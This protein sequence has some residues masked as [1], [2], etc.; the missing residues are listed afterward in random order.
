MSLFLLSLACGSNSSLDVSDGDPSVDDSAPVEEEEEEDPGT[1]L[2]AGDWTGDLRIEGSSSFDCD[3][4]LDVEFEEDG[5]FSGDGLCDFGSWS[6]ESDVEIEGA[7]DEDGVLTG[8]LWL[9]YRDED[10][11]LDVS[12]QAD[13]DDD[14]DATLEGLYV[15][16]GGWGDYE[17]ELGGEIEFDLD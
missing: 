12:G 14:I 11:E 13:D 5:S 9:D 2:W 17:I 16:E 10:V 3:G 6:G 15:Y 8:T 7:I 1:A 4:E